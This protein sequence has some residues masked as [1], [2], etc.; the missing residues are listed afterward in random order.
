MTAP[1]MEDR[2]IV[3]LDARAERASVRVVSQASVADL[4]RP[5]PCAR[6]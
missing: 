6:R 5:T 3:G 2:D 4:A 1:G